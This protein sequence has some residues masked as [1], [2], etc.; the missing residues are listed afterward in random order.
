MQD[1]SYKA[2]FEQWAK[3]QAGDAG[4]GKV[5]PPGEATMGT[6]GGVGGGKPDF[7]RHARNRQLNRVPP[8]SQAFARKL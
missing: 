1:A 8:I 2:W 4:S 6:A 5:P 3:D 7:K